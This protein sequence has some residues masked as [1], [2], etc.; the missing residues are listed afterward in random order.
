MNREALLWSNVA[1]E[2]IYLKKKIRCIKL[3]SQTTNLSKRWLCNTMNELLIIDHY[4]FFQ[5][6]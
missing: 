5:N 6:I 4:H 1:A 2:L 3:Y